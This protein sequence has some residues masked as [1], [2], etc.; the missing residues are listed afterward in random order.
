MWLCYEQ[1]WP[2]P[3][4]AEA[5]L[6]RVRDFPSWCLRMECAKCGRDRYLGE[7]HLTLDGMGEVRIGG[8]IGRMRALRLR[9]SS[10]LIELVT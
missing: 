8:M 5:L 6:A 2:D 1:D 3:T 10:Q 7:T 9:R 4:P